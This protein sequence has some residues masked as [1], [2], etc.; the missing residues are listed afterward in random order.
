V[1]GVGGRGRTRVSTSS[2]LLDIPRSNL[3]KRERRDSLEVIDFVEELQREKGKKGVQKGRISPT[4]RYC[5]D[6]GRV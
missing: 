6:H 4:L 5:A 2:F 1:G 3:E